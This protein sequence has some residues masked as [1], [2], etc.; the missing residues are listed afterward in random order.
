MAS[1]TMEF[2][3]DATGYGASKLPNLK[4]YD[5]DGRQIGFVSYNGRVWLGD[6]DNKVEIPCAS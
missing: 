5:V 2:F 1:G 3:R 6:A 4:L